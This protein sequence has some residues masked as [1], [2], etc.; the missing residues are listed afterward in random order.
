MTNY[1]TIKNS[2]FD[3]L[4]EELI[5]Q[6]VSGLEKKLEHLEKEITKRK[7]M[8]DQILTTLANQRI[9]FENELW[10]NRYTPLLSLHNN[11]NQFLKDKLMDITIAETREKVS[12]FRDIFKLNERLLEIQ[13]GLAQSRIKSELISSEE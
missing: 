5:S 2:K 11:T 12:S 7:N 9:K 4:L 3:I 13:D 8:R 6:P 1:G 10:I